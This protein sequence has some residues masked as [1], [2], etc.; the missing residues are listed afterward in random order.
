MSDQ[1]NLQRRDVL[2]GLAATV[3]ASVAVSTV[4]QTSTAAAAPVQGNVTSEPQATAV[5][6][7]AV[8]VRATGRALPALFQ[9]LVGSQVDRWKVQD[10]ASL[11]GSFAVVMA[12]ETG[13]RFQVDVLGRDE[14]APGVSNTAHFS[15]YLSN[16][17]NGAT[18]SHEEHGLGAMALGTVLARLE[19]E[20]EVP[21]GL[22]TLA[23]RTSRFP[24]AS[25]MRV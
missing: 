9:A 1:S 7:D 24:R 23:Q 11:Q 17:G 6:P 3:G 2:K 16:Q 4:V 10:V 18:P 14:S 12:T 22:L 5:V 8:E 21:S 13:D 25:F 19:N 15:V 20:H